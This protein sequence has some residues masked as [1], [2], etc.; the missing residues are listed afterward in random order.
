MV[1][2]ANLP[3]ESSLVAAVVGEPA[4]WAVTDHLV[5]HAV[6]G[7]NQL[8]YAYVAAHSKSKP[9]APKPVPRPRSVANSEHAPMSTP[10]EVRSFMTALNTGR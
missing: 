4:E 7:I 6:D 8:L 5:A 2:C 9:P 3:R 1:L 10:N